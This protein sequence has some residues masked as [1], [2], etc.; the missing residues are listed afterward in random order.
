L[1]CFGSV[2]IQRFGIISALLWRQ[3]KAI[4]KNKQPPPKG[5]NPNG[6]SRLLIN[7]SAAYKDNIKYDRR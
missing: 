7:G 4:A 3:R 2:L 6:F 5:S 1:G